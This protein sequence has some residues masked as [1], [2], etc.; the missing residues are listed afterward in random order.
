MTWTR[1]W[2]TGPVGYERWSATQLN[3][4]ATIME[5]ACIARASVV[6]RLHGRARRRMRKRAIRFFHAAAHYR[7]L[8]QG[9]P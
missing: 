9:R 1:W 5:R 3:A 2:I 4:Q 6:G 7:N 8:A